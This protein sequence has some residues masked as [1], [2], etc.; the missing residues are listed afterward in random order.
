MMKLVRFVTVVL[1]LIGCQNGMHGH[2]MIEYY[3]NNFIAISC[4]GRIGTDVQYSN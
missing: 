1:L 4:I 3:D 2:D